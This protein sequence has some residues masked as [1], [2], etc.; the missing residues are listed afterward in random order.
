MDIIVCDWGM[1]QMDGLELLSKLR[2]NRLDRSF[3]FILIT[4]ENCP[5]KLK[6][7]IALGVDDYIVKPFQI[8]QFH[9]RLI[10]MITNRVKYPTPPAELKVTIIEYMPQ[11]L[12]LLKGILGQLGFKQISEFSDSKAALEH[13]KANDCDLVLSDWSMPEM[14]GLELHSKLQEEIRTRHTPFILITAESDPEKIRAAIAEGIDGYLVKPF[15]ID[16]IRRELCRVLTLS[17]AV[18]A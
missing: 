14:D 8:N 3:S 12:E 15:H 13:L 10:S 4:A 2:P 5:K 7:A 18:N 6:E 9:Q 1:P 17:K 11:I 16:A